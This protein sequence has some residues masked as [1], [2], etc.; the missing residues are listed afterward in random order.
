MISTDYDNY[1]CTICDMCIWL[2]LDYETNVTGVS[3]M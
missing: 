1:I 3:Y 2:T